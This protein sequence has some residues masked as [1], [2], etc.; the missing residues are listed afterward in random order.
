[1]TRAYLRLDPHLADRKATYPDGA[2]RAFVEC[3]CFA[4]QQPERGY[5]RNE[6][7]LR[8]MLEKRARW[9]PFLIEHDDLIRQ[10]DGRIYLDGW[11]EW[12]EGDVTVPER[13]QRL[14]NR[15]QG[16]TDDVTPPVTSPTVSP[17]SSG[18]G[19]QEA[20]TETPRRNDGSATFM[21]YRPKPRDHFGQHPG[22]AVCAPLQVK[23]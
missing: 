13:M 19:K 15:K 6:K 11:K 16:V 23:S 9:V 10:P 17:P 20:S 18:S 22:C 12:Q 7:L 2:F 14:R 1:M 8:V 3:L 5:F 21:G 4:V